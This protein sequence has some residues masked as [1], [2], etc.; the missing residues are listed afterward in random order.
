MPQMQVPIIVGDKKSKFSDYEDG[1]P[2]N[3]IAVARDIENA[4]GYLYSHDGL[5]QLFL[6]RG[7][8]RGALFNERMGRS[9]RVSGQFLI[10]IVDDG[11]VVIGDIP[12]AGF[13]GDGDPDTPPPYADYV[14]MPYS[15]NSFIIVSIGKVYRYDGTNLIQINDPDL[16]T[17]IDATWIDGYYFFTDGEHLYHTDIDDETSI[18]PLKFATSELSPDPTKAVGRTQDDLVVVFNRYTT[19]YFVNQ[20]NEQFAFSRLNQKAVSAGIVGTKCWTEMDGNL[21]ILGGR[22]EE[23]VSVHILGSGQTINISTRLI[24]A[25]IDQYTETELSHAKLECRTSDRDQLLYVRLPNE[26]LVFNQSIAKKFGIGVAWSKLET[27]GGNW[28]A[29]NIIYDPVLNCWL[30]GDNAGPRIFKMDKDTAS[31]DGQSIDSYFYTPLVPI[32]SA[33]VDQV[34]LNTV[35]GFGD[36]ST[37]LFIST[38]RDGAIYSQEYSKYVSVFQDY[39]YRYI[40][41]RLGY[42]RKSIG[43]KFRAHH[44][45]K[46]NVSGMSIIYG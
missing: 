15:F 12:R 46:I 8:D 31:F 13:E 1:I 33:S 7:A 24:D 22:K 42:V 21:F 26:T 38:T 43:F 41:T 20:G 45:D 44:K 40:V 29:A 23:R 32:E 39:D 2:V 6:G 10:E 19:E 5:T 11:A 25:I 27:N 28:R 3:L 37:A 4:T 34:E 36:K 35:S 14:S 16:G 18:D 17:P 9:F 30:C